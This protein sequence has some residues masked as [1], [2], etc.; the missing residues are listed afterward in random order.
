[1]SLDEKIGQMLMPGWEIDD[2]KIARR[3]IVDYHVGGYHVFGGDAAA[4]ALT[5]NE[6]QRL[7]RVPLLIADN[8]EGGVGYVLFGAT[9]LPL[10]MAIAATGD[11]QLAYQA[12][13]VTAEEGR[14]LGVEVNFYPVADVNNNARNPIINIRSFGEDPAAVSRFVRAD[15]GDAPRP[16]RSPLSWS[17]PFRQHWVIETC[18]LRSGLPENETK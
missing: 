8:F 16:T 11:E 17:A 7:A 10:A 3:N 9:R 15:C 13:K 4:V 2:F 18:S 1:M 5:I 14:A 6:M 12:A